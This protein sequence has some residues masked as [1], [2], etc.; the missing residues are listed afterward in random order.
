M[1][2]KK[3]TPEE[4]NENRIDLR[5]INL[6]A[7]G[8]PLPIDP[9]T[10]KID[11]DKLTDAQRAEFEEASRKLAEAIAPAI[12]AIDA[13]AKFTKAVKK[14]FEPYTAAIR[15]ITENA[16]NDTT[17]EMLREALESLQP[18]QD[19]L[20]EI[21]ELKPYIKAELKKEE[22][23]GKT[24]D[25]IMDYTPGELLELR[26]DPSSDVYKVFEAAKAAKE[27]EPLDI[28]TYR[29]DKLNTP[30]DRVNF[31]AWDNFKDTG[32]Q[33]KFNLMSDRDKRNPER[34]N[35]DISMRYSLSF[36]DDPEIK[37]TK[38]TNHYDRRL[39]QA[40]DT[41]YTAGKDVFLP[42]EA[43][44][45]MGGTG[46]PSAYQLKLINASL[47]KQGTARI[48][49]NNEA[50]AAEYDY[51]EIHY[52]GNILN[53]ERI[54]VKYKGQEREAIKML[55]RPVLMEFADQRDNLTAVPMKVLQSDVSK[56]DKHLR[57]EDYLLTRIVRQKKVINDL[58]E[59]QKK[60]YTQ[61]RAREIREAST[62]SIRLST[63]YDH[64]GN[65]KK[66]AIEQQRALK[67]AER[68]LQHYQSDKANY[69]I[70][71]YSIKDDKIII[72]LP[73]K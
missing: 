32:G 6:T 20:D 7:A 22:Y 17:R 29:A 43:F 31:L 10:G 68:Y 2:D 28:E 46:K 54:K 4:G 69:Y 37:T 71:K 63:F 8:E 33:I 36:G 60:R 27:S 67:T 11:V 66:K 1:S 14:V 56:T 18:I 61:K 44:Y 49:M 48:F 62:F 15:S 13:G 34:C 72:T 3:K 50:E 26:H 70:E 38:E 12:A 39:T 58:R 23:G 45:G 40:I 57:I 16:L 35:L 25:D 41:M 51:P 24:F 30:V 5:E 73:T 64:T 65:L 59:A 19:L 9:D 42:S 47:T 21:D 53:F 52:D 55:R